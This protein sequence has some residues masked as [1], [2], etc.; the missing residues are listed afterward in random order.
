LLGVTAGSVPGTYISFIGSILAQSTDWS[1]AGYFSRRQA[2]TAPCLSQGDEVTQVAQ[3]VVD[4]ITQSSFLHG[5]DGADRTEPED[6]DLL[7]H[8]QVFDSTDLLSAGQKLSLR[9]YLT[10]EEGLV[11]KRKDTVSQGRPPATGGIYKLNSPHIRIHRGDC[12][13]ETLPPA[14]S[15]W[16]TFGL[17]PLLGQKDILP[18]CIFPHN[19]AEDASAFMERLGSTYSSANFGTH[20]AVDDSNGLIPWA[21]RSSDDRDYGSIMLSLQNVCKLLGMRIGHPML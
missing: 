17:E 14:I 5:I 3:L 11:G 21:L 2:D 16:E 1:F 18:Y 15:F 10:L 6:G 19:T 13:L 7:M 4:Q 8:C 9:A 20:S 12:Y